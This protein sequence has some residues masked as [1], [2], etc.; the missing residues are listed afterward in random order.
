LRDTGLGRDIR[1]YCPRRRLMH[2]DDYASVV[3]DTRIAQVRAHMSPQPSKVFGGVGVGITAAGPAERFRPHLPPWPRRRT[4]TRARHAQSAQGPG[5]IRAYL[6][7]LERSNPDVCPRASGVGVLLCGWWGWRP[8]GLR[9]READLDELADLDEV[10]LWPLGG[11]GQN[12]NSRST[13]G[14]SS[15]LFA[16]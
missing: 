10:D 13:S 8:D 6:Q 7:L 5:M 11:V 4:I 2:W 12:G 1:G 3:G 14:L 9:R 15:G 16:A